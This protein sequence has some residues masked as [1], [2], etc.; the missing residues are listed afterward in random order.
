MEN[1][2][3]TSEKVRIELLRKNMTQ[4]ELA[5]KLGLDQMTIS[6]RIQSNAWR[7]TEVFFM[8]HGLKFEL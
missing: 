3:T 7:S 2:L 8:K 6:R 5:Q 1:R 4:A